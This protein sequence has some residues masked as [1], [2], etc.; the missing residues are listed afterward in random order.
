[1]SSASLPCQVT[2]D[3]GA[4][5]T[6]GKPLRFWMLSMVLSAALP[7]GSYVGRRLGGLGFFQIWLKE[8][9]LKVFLIAL[10]KNGDSKKVYFTIFTA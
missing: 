5:T 2:A 1:M 3:S 7:V 9:R 6:G 4:R 8:Y 10:L